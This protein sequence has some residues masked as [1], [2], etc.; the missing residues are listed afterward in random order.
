[1]VTPK[2]HFE[3]YCPLQSRRPWVCR[4]CHGTPRFWQISLPYFNQGGQIM[5]T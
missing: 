5:P 2:E 1:L 3:I 4:V